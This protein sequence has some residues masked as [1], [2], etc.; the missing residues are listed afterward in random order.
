MLV[1]S[2]CCFP[3]EDQ[4]L[5]LLWMNGLVWAMHQGGTIVGPGSGGGTVRGGGGGGGSGSG[6]GGE[7][8]GERGNGAFLGL[9]L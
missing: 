2:V 7:M 8:G 3:V 6:S 9:E 1:C 5:R 4:K